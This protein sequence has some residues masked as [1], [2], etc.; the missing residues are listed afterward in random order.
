MDQQHTGQ[1]FSG[2]M[3]TDETAAAAAQRGAVQLGIHLEWESQEV[4]YHD[5]PLAESV[6]YSTMLHER[7]VHSVRLKGVKL[8]PATS[9]GLPPRSAANPVSRKD[10]RAHAAQCKSFHWSDARRQPASST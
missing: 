5:D 7:R 9:A 6:N 2:T 10:S 3:L 1:V 8:S 4:S